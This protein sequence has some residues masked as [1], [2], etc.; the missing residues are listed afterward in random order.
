MLGPMTASPLVSASLEIRNQTPYPS[1]ADVCSPH[2]DRTTN[3]WQ[4][5]V[6]YTRVPANRKDSSRPVLDLSTISDEKFCNILEDIREGKIM[7]KSVLRD[8]N[9]WTGFTWLLQSRV[10]P[11]IKK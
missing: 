10:E 2:A 3:L 8:H 5:T 6:T 9:K 1:L 11:L 4:R 7:L